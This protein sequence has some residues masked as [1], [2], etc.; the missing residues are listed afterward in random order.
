MDD[1]HTEKR[2]DEWKKEFSNLFEKSPPGFAYHYCHTQWRSDAV[3]GKTDWDPWP[4]DGRRWHIPR[5]PKPG[6]WDS[7][8]VHFHRAALR[9][10]HT[11]LQK[12]P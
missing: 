6:F 3:E 10:R 4:E 2:C 5:V 8:W 11:V 7:L 1:G 12:L 9:Q